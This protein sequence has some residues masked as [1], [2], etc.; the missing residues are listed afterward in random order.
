MYLDW[1]RLRIPIP[2]ARQPESGTAHVIKNQLF[3]VH[4]L[5]LPLLS[6]PLP[7]IPSFPAASRLASLRPHRS[8][9]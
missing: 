5:V 8:D 6:I 2:P 1:E 3:L 4:Y 9:S 7:T